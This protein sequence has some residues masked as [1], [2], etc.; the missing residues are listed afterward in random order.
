[1]M[2]RMDQVRALRMLTINTTKNQITVDLITKAGALKVLVEISRVVR[3][4]DTTYGR[5]SVDLNTREA[6]KGKCS[7]NPKCTLVN[8]IVKQPPDPRPFK[9][10][11][12]M[13]M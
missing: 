8:L 3:A 13:Q 2:P 5:L 1:M 10:E 4:V 9:F 6:T 12:L 7:L 11:M